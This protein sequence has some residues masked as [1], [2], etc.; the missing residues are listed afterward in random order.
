MV[1]LEKISIV[2]NQVLLWIAGLFLVA[3]ITITGANIFSR[4]FWA[5]D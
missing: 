1:V 5:S 3:M 4:H 2:L